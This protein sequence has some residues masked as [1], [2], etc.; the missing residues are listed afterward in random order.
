MNLIDLGLAVLALSFALGIVRAVRGP[1]VGDRAIAADLCLYAIVGAIALLTLR[2][3][4]D[5]FLDVIL[6]ATLLGFLA[7]IALGALVGRRDS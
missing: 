5:E 2:T 1:S 6:I 3:T 7:T 4:Y